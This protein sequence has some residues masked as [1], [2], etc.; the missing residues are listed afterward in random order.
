[1][2]PSAQQR[3]RELYALLGDLPERNRPISAKKIS[4]R[5]TPH[6]IL[7]KL[8]LDLNGIEPVPAYLARPLDASA[9]PRPTVLYSHS[10]GGR[11]DIGKDELLRGREYLHSPPYAKALTE[12]GFN[13]L[14]IDAW[15][16]GERSGRAE[17]SVFKEMLW[18]GRVLWG[19]MLYDG[20]RAI[21]YLHARPDVDA[22]RIATLGMSMGST[23]SW[24]LAALDERVAACVDICC[25]TDFDAILDAG[26]LDEHGLYY[27]VPGLLKHFS[28]A[29]IN[30]LI[31]PRPHLSLA[32]TIDP[33]TPVAGLDRIDAHLRA[34]YA[35]LG[36][37]DAWC[38]FRSPTAHVE[39]P[40]MRKEILAFLRAYL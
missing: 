23:A 18:R 36:V 16:F 3:R 2:S 11:Y 40:E 27:Y 17:S 7:E 29:D 21:D 31:A 39:T 9:E 22:A 35:S 12:L 37:P 19:M 34:V 33:L 13:I 28:A 30:A 38:L 20:L 8:V 6:Y 1:M 15:I 5:R 26:G 32:G 14:C 25:L 4:E 24:W 10:H